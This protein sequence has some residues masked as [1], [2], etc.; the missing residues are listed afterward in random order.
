MFIGFRLLCVDISQ[1][2][3]EVRK[4]R[5][6]LTDI[7]SLDGLCKKEYVS[8]R[9]TNISQLE[10]LLERERLCIV[11]IR[12]E[13]EKETPSMNILDSVSRELEIVHQQ[14]VQFEFCLERRRTCD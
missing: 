9:I 4:I 10:R 7:P 11:S 1:I 8:E 2:L 13:L 6:N 12:K 5:E 3:K 14:A